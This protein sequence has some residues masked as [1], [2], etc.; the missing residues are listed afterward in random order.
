MMARTSPSCTC[1]KRVD[2][3]PVDAKNYTDCMHQEMGHLMNGT[4]ATGHKYP[5]QQAIAASMNICRKQFKLEKKNLIIA[6][7]ETM[8]KLREKDVKRV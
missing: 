8:I 6:I 1:G 7:L 3:L 2:K 4:N 5:R